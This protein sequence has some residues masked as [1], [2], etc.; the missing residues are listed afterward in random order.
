MLTENIGQA[1]P[2]ALNLILCLALTFTQFLNNTEWDFAVFSLVASTNK[3]L[4]L[5]SLRYLERTLPTGKQGIALLDHEK[6]TA[7]PMPAV[8]GL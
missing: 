2:V 3:C 4:C 5:Y 1:S 8:C 7:R 6:E